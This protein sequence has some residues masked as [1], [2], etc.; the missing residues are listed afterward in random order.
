MVSN[1]KWVMG[2][3]LVGGAVFVGTQMTRSRPSPQRYNT[4]DYFNVVSNWTSRALM[5]RVPNTLSWPNLVRKEQYT[6][7]F[8][9]SCPSDWVVLVKSN[10]WVG[11]Y[12]FTNFNGSVYLGPHT[13][14]Y[15][16]INYWV[17]EWEDVPGSPDHQVRITRWYTT[18]VWNEHPLMPEEGWNKVYDAFK[19]PY[20][21][22]GFPH[23]ISRM[24]YHEETNSYWLWTSGKTALKVSGFNSISNGMDGEYVL[25]WKGMLRDYVAPVIDHRSYKGSSPGWPWAVFQANP[26]FASEYQLN[27]YIYVYQNAGGFRLID[28]GFVGGGK[29]EG[30][31]STSAVIV[32]PYCRDWGQSPLAWNPATFPILSNRWLV[33]KATYLP[34]VWVVGG[35]VEEMTENDHTNDAWSI[36]GAVSRADRS[37]FTNVVTHW[38]GF[39]PTN[40]LARKAPQWEIACRNLG[41]YSSQNL[42]RA[43]G[44]V[45]GF[46]LPF[47]RQM[48]DAY[49]SWLSSVYTW[50]EGN[51]GSG[52]G[53]EG[54][55]EARFVR[56]EVGDDESLVFDK[57]EE[58]RKRGWYANPGQ[59]PW[60]AYTGLLKRA[61]VP[62]SIW[63]V[64]SSSYLRQT[65]EFATI[66]NVLTFLNNTMTVQILSPDGVRLNNWKTNGIAGWAGSCS[67]NWNKVNSGSLKDSFHA[68]T[69]RVFLNDN[70]FRSLDNRAF[71]RSGQSS[72]RYYQS[73]GYVTWSNDANTCGINIQ[74][75]RTESITPPLYTGFSHRVRMYAYRGWTNEETRTK[76]SLGSHPYSWTWETIRLKVWDCPGTA[77]FDSS[78]TTTA[79]VKVAD[80]GWVTDAFVAWKPFT[81]NWIPT[82][83]DSLLDELTAPPSDPPPE[84]TSHWYRTFEVEYGHTID[85][86][87][88]IIQWRP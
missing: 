67:T 26:Y 43:S 82:I 34:F 12:P 61:G 9:G 86:G 83:P 75:N 51:E 33:S 44:E 56:P 66:T 50:F 8:G 74:V 45:P 10:D 52:P 60:M 68:A 39:R 21:V 14:W 80:S 53:I 59:G 47:S 69:N 17:P 4:T 3:M 36:T 30:D 29:L 28:R 63:G 18:N 13:N 38:G 41:D 20:D 84:E 42:W 6:V 31:Y 65:N 58:L 48:D 54:M 32:S 40:S 1:K 85:R 5:L 88:V 87:P 57:S 71:L 64:P 24:I 2:L 16:W 72:W 73:M 46:F 35:K 62:Q 49:H 19:Y 76:F 70:N 79:S 27:S 77:A 81:D 15:C 11:G 7:P 78:L 55:N 23:Y 37:F 22:W 25:A